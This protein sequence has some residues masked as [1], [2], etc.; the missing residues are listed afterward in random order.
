MASAR[1]PS[2]TRARAPPTSQGFGMTKQPSRWRR[3]NSSQRGVTPQAYSLDNRCADGT[4]QPRNNGRHIEKS[5]GVEKLAENEGRACH[6]GPRR[7][8]GPRTP[9]QQESARGHGDPLRDRR[10]EG[11]GRADVRHAEGRPGAREGPRARPRPLG[12]RLVRSPH[13]RGLRR[14]PG[15]RDAGPDGPLVPGLR[16]LGHRRH[17]LLRAVRPHAAR[18][19]EGRGL[20]AKA[21]GVPEAGRLRPHGLPR[22]PRQEERR[23]ARSCP[24]CPSPSA[25]RTTA[26]TSSRR[27]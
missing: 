4:N 22:A 12:H 24:S 2:W 27:A 16:Q 11:V 21:R 7:A 14:R 15:P 8:R 5:E 6:R 18:V 26:G 20:V 19:R 9:G 1:N 3:R 13:G 10:E 17:D 23:R 25:P